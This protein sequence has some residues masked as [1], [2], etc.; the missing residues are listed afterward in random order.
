MIDY[1]CPDCGSGFDHRLTREEEEESKKRAQEMNK[2]KEKENEMETFSLSS[3][4]TPKTTT[5]IAATGVIFFSILCVLSEYAQ[6]RGEAWILPIVICAFGL[7][8]ML[9]NNRKRGVEND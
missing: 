3:L 8:F 7:V 9:I 4:L 6:G 1:E 2:N 5:L